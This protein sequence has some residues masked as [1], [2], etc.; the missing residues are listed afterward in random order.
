M[1]VVF[2]ILQSIFAIQ[3]NKESA[4]A[5][6][7]GRCG[8]DPSTICGKNKKLPVAA[9]SANINSLINILKARCIPAAYVSG[10][11]G[12]PGDFVL[13]DNG[14]LAPWNRITNDANYS[15]CLDICPCPEYLNQNKPTSCHSNKENNKPACSKSPVV[16][17]PCPQKPCPVEPVC[18]PVNHCPVEP[19]CPKPCEV[20]CDDSS[21]S[22]NE[23]P[24]LCTKRV[25]VSEKCKNIGNNDVLNRECEILECCRNYIID[26]KGCK[27]KKKY[28]LVIVDSVTEKS[29]KNVGLSQRIPNKNC[30]SNIPVILRFPNALLKLQK[31]LE[32]QFGSTVC[33]YI[34]GK[35]CDKLYALIDCKLYYIRICVKD[36]CS[37]KW[38]FESIAVIKLHKKQ[39][40]ELRKNG[41]SKIT[42]GCE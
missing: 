19:V 36:L 21:T 27:N 26:P 2:S 30:N 8:D 32:C 12:T 29:V 34:G 5:L 4:V 31:A 17:K 9:D 15:F 20:T 35:N 28:K 37:K 11:N 14:A 25:K 42:F 10:W 40:R 1:F 39:V 33:L 7:Q 16:N 6:I 3:F 13:R 22:E 18:P 23:C 38:K 24:P 41:L